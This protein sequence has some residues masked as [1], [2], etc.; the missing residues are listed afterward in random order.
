MSETEIKVFV[1][2]S[3]RRRMINHHLM[4]DTVYVRDDFLKGCE[5]YPNSNHSY[6]YAIEGYGR[7]KG[8]VYI[9]NSHK[10]AELDEFEDVPRY[11]YKKEMQLESG[12]L[13]YVYLKSE[14][15][16]LLRLAER[17]MTKKIENGDWVEYYDRS[18]C[19]DL[20]Y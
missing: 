1:Y 13:A 20:S 18:S 4:S 17:G 14:K 16:E 9:V 12:D 19:V 10:I 11:Y 5:I 6:P 2:G 8:E 7:L 3:L 15:E